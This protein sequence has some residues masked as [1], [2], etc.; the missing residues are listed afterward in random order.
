MNISKKNANRKEEETRMFHCVCVGQSCGGGGGGRGGG[1][2]GR[3]GG[4]GGGG[5]GEA[6]SLAKGY[7]YLVPLADERN[8][9]RR[10]GYSLSHRIKDVHIHSAVDILM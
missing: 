10:V 3:G 2:G 4:G 5:G 9:D 6:D 7:P 8:H 1:G